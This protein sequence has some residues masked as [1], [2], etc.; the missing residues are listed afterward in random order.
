VTG[1]R[2]PFAERLA[3]PFYGLG[4]RAE[5]LN[6]VAAVA[7]VRAVDRF[8][9]GNDTDFPA[10][11]TLTIVGALRRHFRDHGWTV[12]P[13]RGMQ[14]M[15]LAIKVLGHRPP[16]RPPRRHPRRHQARR[17]PRSRVVKPPLNN[18]HY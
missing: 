9:P 5:D 6:Q 14:E 4:E 16:R 8:D 12:R 2:L 1:E 3:H 7:L 17:G 13:P 11:A 18:H 10:Y 15:R